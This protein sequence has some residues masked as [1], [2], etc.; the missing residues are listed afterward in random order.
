MF[1]LFVSAGQ[2]YPENSLAERTILHGVDDLLRQVID[3][4]LL[5][6]R[7]SQHAAVARLEIPHLQAPHLHHLRRV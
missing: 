6:L 3:L 1:F 5:Q 4:P 7:R 2:N